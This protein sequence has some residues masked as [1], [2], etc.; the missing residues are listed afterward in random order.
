MQALSSNP[1]STQKKKKKNFAGHWWLAPVILATQ[2]AEV[3][4]IVVLSQSGQ[5]VCKILSLKTCH[6]KRADAVAQGTD[7]EFKPQF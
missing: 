4:W 1:S 2:E 5:T 6:K 3:R 7:P